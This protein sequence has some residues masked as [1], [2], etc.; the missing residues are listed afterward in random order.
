MHVIV[1]ILRDAWAVIV[2]SAPFL[3]FG[4]FV[5]GLLHVFLDPA[6]VAR[7]LG[8]GRLRP[9]VMAS[10]LGVPLPLCSCGVLPAALSLRKQG[11]NDGAVTSFLISTP[12]TGV[13]SIAITYALLGPIMAIV[14]PIVAFITGVATG[15]VQTLSGQTLSTKQPAAA[16]RAPDADACKVDACRVDACCA[17]DD[18]PPD[19]HRRHHGVI[20]KAAAG[21]RYAFVDLLGDI[22]GW[23][24]L[25]VLI[26]GII[27][28]LVPDDL[29]TRYLGG[30]VL[31]MLIMLAV[32]VPLYVCSSASTP[33]AAALIL[34][35]LS[36]GAALVFLMAG[37]ATNAAGITVVAGMLGKR[38]AAIYL[39]GIA[40]CSVAMGL[41]LDALLGATGWRV[42][43]KI[44]AGH[45]HGFAPWRLV[46]AGVFLAAVAALFLARILPRLKKKP[47]APTPSAAPCPHCADEDEPPT[48]S[49]H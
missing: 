2:E 18:C 41:L 7:H 39:G 22:A 23:F 16:P 11:A 34:K 36:P 46:L 28:F 48:P 40:V 45:Q 32:G 19:E 14:R 27:T 43:P 33:I 31:T 35:G 8:R 44:T 6:I 25:G 24:L 15:F 17:G 12:A 30:G 42:V 1:G 38:A 20:V 47:P 10:L 9:V 49:C 37:P 29:I 13:D 26:A 21:L 5:A 3:I 4:L